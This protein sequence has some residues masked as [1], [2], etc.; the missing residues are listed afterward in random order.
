MTVELT[1]TSKGQVTLKKALLKHLGLEPGQKISVS[2]LPG[3]RVEL[4]PA[5]KKHDITALRGLLRRPAQRAMTIEE[6]QQGIRAGAAARM[7]RSK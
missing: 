3:G 6:M 5:E 2:L 4:H 7:L 1:V